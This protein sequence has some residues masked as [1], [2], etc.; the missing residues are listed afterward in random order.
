MTL[1]TNR[2]TR[3]TYLFLK[4]FVTDS[5]L[6]PIQRMTSSHYSSQRLVPWVSLGSFLLAYF[7]S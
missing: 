4:I 3:N 2:G 1:C 7:G 6:W 5:I